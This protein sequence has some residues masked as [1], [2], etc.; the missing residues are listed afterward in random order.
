MGK[1]WLWNDNLKHVVALVLALLGGFACDFLFVGFV[2][3]T[4][5]LAVSSPFTG[6]LALTMALHL[7]VASA[8][9]QLPLLA[10]NQLRQVAP[11]QTLSGFPAVAFGLI[12]ESNFV[13]LL[14]AAWYAVAAAGLLVHKL[15]WPL[16]GRPMYAL[17]RFGFV[18]HRRLVLIVGVGITM[19]AIPQ[20]ERW[21]KILAGAIR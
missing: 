21:L 8:L 20:S 17:Q 15:L 14:V 2:R 13:S 9:I 5:K 1:D 10:Q 11:S 7:L 12:S 19:L 3:R 6:V 18:R 16:L 4:L